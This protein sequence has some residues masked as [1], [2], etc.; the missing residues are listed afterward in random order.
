MA[1]SD[2]TERL[3]GPEL[4]GARGLVKYTNEGAP[5]G[6]SLSRAAELSVFTF[7]PLFRRFFLIFGVLKFVG[8]R[9]LK[10]TQDQF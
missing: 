1:E 10:V 4:T 9:I 8:F 2:T 6:S 5:S 7:S 3:N